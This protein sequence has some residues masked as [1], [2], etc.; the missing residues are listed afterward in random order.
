MF[1]YTYVSVDAYSRPLPAE[2]SK[3]RTTRSRVASRLYTGASPPA[4]RLAI[5]R[6]RR[7][8]PLPSL[9][10]PSPIRPPSSSASPDPGSWHRQFLGWRRVASARAT[11][12]AQNGRRTRGERGVSAEATSEHTRRKAAGAGRGSAAP[13]RG[14]RSTPGAK[15]RECAAGAGATAERPGREVT[16]A[17]QP[18]CSAH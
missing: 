8:P 16:A 18:S 7:Q 13:A 6:V 1:S 14:R 15:Q 3:R 17:G 2:R 10:P 9:A 11:H 12:H 4:Q 5:D